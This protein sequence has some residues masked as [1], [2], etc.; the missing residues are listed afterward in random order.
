MSITLEEIVAVQ[1][2]ALNTLPRKIIYLMI[3]NSEDDTGWA[4]ISRGAFSGATTL[5][6]RSVDYVIKHLMSVGLIERQK[7]ANNT[8]AVYQYRVIEA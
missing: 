8:N 4:T 7:S 5:S 1:H 3:R 6:R 2:Q